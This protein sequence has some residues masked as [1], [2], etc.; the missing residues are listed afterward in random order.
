MIRHLT[1]GRLLLPVLL[2]GLAAF[3]PAPTRAQDDP[4]KGEAQTAVTKD[5][6]TVHFTYWNAHEDQ[7]T[8]VVVLVHGRNENRLVWTAKQT[9]PFL[10][11]KGYAVIAVDLRKHGE[12]M[13]DEN[14]PAA[15][16]SSRITKF[17][18]AAMIGMDL[19]AIKKF[20]YQEHQDK[21]LN[22]R[23]LALVG[24]DM[25]TVLVMNYALLDWNKKPYD[26]APTVETRTPRGQDVRA[27]VLLSP[28]ESL[29]GLSVITPVR[30]LRTTGM[31]ALIM[32]GSS[33]S[34]KR[35]ATKIYQQLGGDQQDEETQ[36]LYQQQFEIKLQGTGLLGQN[37]GTENLLL[38]F[39]K[40]HVMD[41]EIPWKDRKSRLAK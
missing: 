31:A 11:T 16:R 34:G 17:D 24:S 8:P 25:S 36:R 18:Y 38:G 5:G 26:D 29:S 37:V 15:A 20:I 9:A 28:M 13:A 21:K 2:A 23:K 22:M 3:A 40:K 4:T 12:T 6:W 14:A 41:L 33:S 27:V 19:E 32:Y 39:L 1:P 30:A 10:S 35:T 7:D